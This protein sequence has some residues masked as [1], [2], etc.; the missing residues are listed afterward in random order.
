MA[1]IASA[2]R[3]LALAVILHGCMG[4]GGTKVIIMPEG[5]QGEDEAHG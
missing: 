1:D 5:A 2:L 3:Y 4:I